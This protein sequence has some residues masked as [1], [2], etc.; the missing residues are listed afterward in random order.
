MVCS[1]RINVGYPIR[2]A[3]L[4]LGWATD[5]EFESRSGHRLGIQSATQA[6]SAWPSL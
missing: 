6:N 4:V 5:H 2:R 3:R 1:G